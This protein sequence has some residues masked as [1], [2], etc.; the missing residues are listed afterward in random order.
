M[1][2]AVDAMGGDDAPEAIIQGCR[3]AVRTYEDI[4]IFLTGK[5]ELIS[6]MMDENKKKVS[7]KI[8]IVDCRQKITME[9][10]PAQALRKK[11]DTSIGR[12]A[13]LVKEG[14]AGSLFSA[15][16]TGASLSAGILIIGRI[17]GIIRPAIATLFPSRGKPTLI[18]DIGAN[19]NCEPEYLLQ[20][21]VMGQIYADSLLERN[22]PSVGL[23]NVG[24]ERGKG[25]KMIEKAFDLLNSD[26]R[27]NNFA[28]NVEGRDLFTGKYDVVV[29]D[30]FVGNVVL[31]TVEGM[32]NFMMDLLKV[33]FK[34]S[35]RAKLG[36]LLAKNS[37]KK[38]KS[39]VD[40]REYGGAPMLGLKGNVIIGHGSSDATAV[41]NGIGVAR[42]A[43]RQD[44]V[45]I[46]AEEINEDGE[47]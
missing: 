5:K 23:M 21:A 43:I 42:E 47:D 44:I 9:E 3:E 30:G 31:K 29:C 27:L 25:N 14:K 34:R 40:Y 46:I 39:S 12:A 20:F 24:E 4:E 15:G 33:A 2:I 37:L 36:G 32:G 8:N 22:N 6:P 41:K 45:N 28:G 19:A 18:L 26:T 10:K 7:E 11:K 1:K 17:S 16:S 38:M 35:A 13:E